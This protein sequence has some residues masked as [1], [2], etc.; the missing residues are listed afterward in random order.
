VED[1]SSRSRLGTFNGQR[2]V[3]ESLIGN[4]AGT[5]P[6][7][8][9][10]YRPHFR[11]IK[12]ESQELNQGNAWH[13]D[14]SWV[15]KSGAVEMFEIIIADNPDACRTE[16]EIADESGNRIAIMYEDS[17]GWHTEII[18][19]QLEQSSSSFNTLIE[20]AKE[21]LSHYVNRRGDMCRAN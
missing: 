10:L 14:A 8:R 16:A 21:M 12:S 18:D 9:F 13:C 15:T 19:N 20:N 5:P 2:P 7:S 1:P 4:G 11:R 6:V 17:D 3:R